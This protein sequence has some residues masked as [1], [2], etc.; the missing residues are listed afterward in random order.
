MTLQCPWC[1]EWRE[2]ITRMNMQFCP[3][4]SDVWDPKECNDK[5][6]SAVRVPDGPAGTKWEQKG[7]AT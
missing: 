7:K 4:C 6:G 2:E 5:S 1:H 3:E